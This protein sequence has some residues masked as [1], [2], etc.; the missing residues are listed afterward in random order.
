MAV[1]YQVQADVH[2]N[3]AQWS[4]EIPHLYRYYLY[5]TPDWIT[6]PDAQAAVFLLM[7]DCRDRLQSS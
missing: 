2:Q 7:N 1:L 3:H 6:D 5:Y 4:K